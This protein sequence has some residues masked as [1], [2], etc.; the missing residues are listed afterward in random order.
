MRKK[1]SI[2]DN[3]Q[4]PGVLEPSQDEDV[5]KYNSMQED[6]DFE[7]GTSIPTERELFL[8]LSEREKTLPYLEQIVVNEANPHNNLKN[9]EPEVKTFKERAEL[10]LPFVW[11]IWEGMV[12]FSTAGFHKLKRMGTDTKPKWYHKFNT[13]TFHLVALSYLLAITLVFVFEISKYGK[14]HSTKV[15]L[16]K[17]SAYEYNLN[18][19]LPIMIGQYLQFDQLAENT[20]KF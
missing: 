7:L 12:F 19:A 8:E 15:D 16:V 14:V 13:P 4:Q 20:R 1:K 3:I 17:G 5:G 6:P 18:L 10:L 9:Y 2:N 11:M